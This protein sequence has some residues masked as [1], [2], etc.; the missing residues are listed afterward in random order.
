MLTWALAVWWVPWLSGGDL[1][2]CERSVDRGASAGGNDERGLEL[3][4]VDGLTR[5]TCLL[6][7]AR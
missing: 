7:R 1:G 4:C 5:R 6:A 2:R 3:D